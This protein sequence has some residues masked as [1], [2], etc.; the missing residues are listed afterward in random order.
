MVL[1]MYY[2]GK[3]K[4]NFINGKFVKTRVYYCGADTLEEIKQKYID[5]FL[6]KGITDVTIFKK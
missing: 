5:G 2:I 1:N 6:K 3:D 4:V